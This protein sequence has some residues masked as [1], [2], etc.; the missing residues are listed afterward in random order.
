MVS[1]YGC[2]KSKTLT[3]SLPY[4]IRFRQCMVEF[5]HS[6]WKSMRPFANACKYA[7]AFPVI[8]L[9]AMQKTVVTEV[10]AAKGMTVGELS[11]T[12]GRWFGEHR[13]F[14]LWLLAVV[15]NSMFS[16]FWD[17]QKDW[18]LSLLEL[19]TWLPSRGRETF[20]PTHTRTPSQPRRTIWQRV[21]QR[22]HQLS[23]LPTPGGYDSRPSS[24]TGTR[25]AAYWGLRPTLLLP[26][27]SVYYLFTVL[28][29]ILRFTWSLELSSH[30][31]I[32]SDIE[33]GVFMMEALELVRRWMWVFVRVEW[34]AVRMGEMTRFRAPGHVERTAVLWD[35]KNED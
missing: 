9:S 23:P 32:I 13:L 4:I 35:D 5:Y 34:E 31:H 33:S 3:Y 12:S 20:T 14:R 19:D 16:F 28:D 27:P 17:V 7:S 25:R 24:P 1:T 6:G 18:G 2:G 15:V 29:L 26:D 21:M 30:L 22:T 11:Q 8:F 10:A